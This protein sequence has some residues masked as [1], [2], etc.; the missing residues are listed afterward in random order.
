MCLI[1]KWRFPKRAK[2]DIICYKVF[3]NDSTFPLRTPCMNERMYP[4]QI[5]YAHGSS[6]YL[7]R[8]KRQARIKTA[9]YIHVL[10]C[11]AVLVDAYCVYKCIIPKHTKYHESIDG[12]EYCAEK[13]YITDERIY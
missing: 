9:G 2:K 1:S 4:C 5:V 11:P 10:S 3:M 12:N 7:G 6:L 8:S 13:V